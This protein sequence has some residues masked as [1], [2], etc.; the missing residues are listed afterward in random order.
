MVLFIEFKESDGKMFESTTKEVLL[1]KLPFFYIA[2]ELIV[3][4]DDATQLE[5]VP[6]VKD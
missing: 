2:Y 4:L 5:S 6:K 3:G 1:A